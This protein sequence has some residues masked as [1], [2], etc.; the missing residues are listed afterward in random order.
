MRLK[1]IYSI[2][3]QRLCKHH[4]YHS[5]ADA[6]HFNWISK[7]YSLLSWLSCCWKYNSLS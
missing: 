3:N 1:Y 6:Q 7:S 5:S 2:Y 4:S